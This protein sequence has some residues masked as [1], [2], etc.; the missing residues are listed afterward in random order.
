VSLTA[1]ERETVILFSDAGDTA[2]V[3]THQRTIIT[4]LR[5]NPAAKEIENISFDGTAGA[6]FEIPADWLDPISRPKRLRAG[7]QA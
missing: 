5:R 6:V 7:A 4:K 1:A 3:H 2:T